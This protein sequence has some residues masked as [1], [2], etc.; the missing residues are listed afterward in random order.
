MKHLSLGLLVGTIAWLQ[1]SLPI[2][3]YAQEG[4][5]ER[6]LQ[7]HAG[8]QSIRINASLIT[9][10]GERQLFIVKK[11]QSMIRSS[12]NNSNGR[13]T[14]TLLFNQGSVVSIL[15]TDGQL[16]VETKQADEAASQLF[17]LLMLN[18]EY[19]FRAVDGFSLSH[20]IFNDYRIEFTYEIDKTSKVTSDVQG[21]RRIIGANLYRLANTET[22]EV[23]LRSFQINSFSKFSNQIEAPQ[24][25]QFIDE[26]TADISHIRVTTVIYN[27]GIPNFLFKIQEAQDSRP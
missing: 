18:P 24:E 25:L 17:D 2:Q 14:F 4:L 12:V 15:D 20:K 1:I 8:V 3:S 11:G 19:H 13:N 5:R 22:K 27:S 6:A 16:K 9:D 26:E 7:S 10:Q 21:K 23:L